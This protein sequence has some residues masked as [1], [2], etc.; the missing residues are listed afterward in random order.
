MRRGPNHELRKTTKQPLNIMAMFN[1]VGSQEASSKPKPMAPRK[2]GSPT[3]SSRPFSVAIPAPKKTPAIPSQGLVTSL[4]ALAF[5]GAPGAVSTAVAF[6]AKPS[7]YVF[8]GADGCDHGHAWAQPGGVRLVPIQH[9]LHRYTLHDLGEIASGIVRGKQC[10]LRSAGRGQLID[11]ALENDSGESIHTEFGWVSRADVAHLR[12]L[13][14][15]L[16]PY[17]TLHQGKDLRARADQLAGADFTFAY[18]S[19]LRSGDSRV[20]QICLR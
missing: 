14:I 16:H 1:A 4:D 5:S 18:D 6:T 13:V 7:P 12:L 11:L 3:L 15:R 10:E 19:I 9:D 2:S 17:V 20:A 8:L